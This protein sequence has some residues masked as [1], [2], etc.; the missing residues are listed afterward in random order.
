MKKKRLHILE[1]L[2]YWLIA[3]YL[4]QNFSALCYMNFKTLI[5]PEKITFELSHFV[6]RIILFPLLMVTFLHY[7]LVFNTTFKRIL[8]TG[9]FII[10][11]SGLEWLSDYVGVLIHVNWQIWWSPSFWLAALMVLIG[12]MTFFRKMLQK[13]GANARM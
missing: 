6:N 11:L 9:S 2:V 1:I 10:L 13:G 8:L 12:V 7:Y 4:Y 3:T 5:I